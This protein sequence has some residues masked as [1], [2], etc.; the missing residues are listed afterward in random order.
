MRLRTLVLTTTGLTFVLMLLGSYVKSLG[1]RFACPDWPLC[2][3][4]VLPPFPT[5]EYTT[6]QIMAEWIHRD[7]AAVVGV[8][9]LWTFLLVRRSYRQHEH[10]VTVSILALGLLLT[11]VVVGAATV[12]LSH[13]MVSVAHQAMAIAFFSSLLL[14]TFLSWRLPVPAAAAAATIEAAPAEDAK[15][16]PAVL[17]AQGHRNVGRVVADYL[18]ILKPRI[19]LL[20]LVSALTSM[21]VA[22]GTDLDPWL[23]TATLIGGALSAGAGNAFN[24]YLERDIDALMTRTRNRPIPSGR[25]PAN[26]VLVY[27]ICLA[28]LSFVML[29]T[30]VN[31]LTALLALGGAVFYIVVYTLWLKRTR[32]S[33]IVIG[34]AAGGFP[35]L[36]GWA[37]VTGQVTL[38]A[39]SL[40]F[41]VFLWTPPHF[42]AIALFRKEEYA[43]AKIPMLPV[44]RGDHE[45]NQQIFLYAVATLL[46][47]T[48]LWFF[49]LVSSVYLLAAMVLGGLFVWMA[50][51]NL[52]DYTPQRAYAL[53]R[54]SIM[55]LGFVFIA[56]AVD[57]VYVMPLLAS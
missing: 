26:H 37:A 27:G 18:S 29:V 38:P 7:V 19:L 3:G 39:L 56:M 16:A 50:F 4:R 15:D 55:Y 10:L 46:C 47:S 34:G 41:L 21:L 35:V 1:A 40:G 36:V 45:T 32:T 52:V 12:E 49:G 23:V 22:V 2:Y 14:L 6:Q 31:I 8:L 54:Y 43:N 13:P 42:W 20:L 57:V 24:M 28:M 48:L 5:D 9:V 11:Q 53:F 44:V 51:K 25:V 17:R 33:N 30:F